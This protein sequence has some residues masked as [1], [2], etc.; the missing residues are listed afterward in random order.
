MVLDRVRDESAAFAPERV[1]LLSPDRRSD[2]NQPDGC[3]APLGGPP[4]SD[5]EQ[6]WYAGPVTASPLPYAEVRALER[7]LVLIQALADHGWSTPSSLAAATGIDRSTI[8]RLLATLVRCGYASQ[9]S[10]DGSYALS[11]RIREL[12]SGVHVDDRL[13]GIAAPLLEQLVATI[14]WPSDLALLTG[15]RLRITASTH[16]LTSMTFFRGLVGKERPIVASALGRA[17]LA[18]MSESE[19]AA[20]LPLLTGADDGAGRDRAGIERS[21][22][23]TRA[24]GYACAISS[25]DEKVSA[26]ALPLLDQRRVI[27]AVNIVFFRAALSPAQAAAQFLAP[28]RATV[29]SIEAALRAG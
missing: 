26:I 1:G 23:Q 25:V 17:I 27:G 3:A 28:L 22:E 4:C 10:G 24:A 8:Y 5:T 13:A 12:A 20:V 18:A 19:L 29:T 16:H 7:G 6:P 21:I 15:G 11:V 2:Q 9:R 14:H